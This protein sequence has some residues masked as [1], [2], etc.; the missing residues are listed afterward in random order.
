MNKHLQLAINATLIT[1]LISLGSQGESLEKED[2]ARLQ[3]TKN[4]TNSCD[5]SNN[6]KL[7]QFVKDLK[8]R[9]IH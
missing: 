5:L 7:S 4:C 3:N 2:L 9:Q 8:H 1:L 6:L